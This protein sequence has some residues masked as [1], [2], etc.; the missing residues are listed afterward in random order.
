MDLAHSARPLFGQMDISE[1]SQFQSGQRRIRRSQNCGIVIAYPPELIPRHRG[2]LAVENPAHPGLGPH[3]APEIVRSSRRHAAKSPRMAISKSP[4]S[5]Q[6]GFFGLL[7]S[8]Q[9]TNCPAGRGN[10]V[11]QE[12]ETTDIAQAVRERGRRPATPLLHGVH[13]RPSL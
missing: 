12:T 3:S 2:V 4:N 7:W 13:A 1:Q 5:V 9:A 8:P 6:R 10:M 11:R